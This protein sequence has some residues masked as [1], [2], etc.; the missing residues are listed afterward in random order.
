MPFHVLPAFCPGID[1][2]SMSH[3]LLLHD[4]NNCAES[5]VLGVF[6]GTLSE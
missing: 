3:V 5:D 1:M 6:P 2:A 4:A